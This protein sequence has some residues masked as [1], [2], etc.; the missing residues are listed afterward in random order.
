MR[1]KILRCRF[2]TA[3]A[4]LDEWE[5]VENSACKNAST[6]CSANVSCSSGDTITLGVP[7]GTDYLSQLLAPVLILDQKTLPTPVTMTTANN[8]AM[9]PVMA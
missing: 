4:E 1:L 9:Q 7:D 8:P 5:R 6:T 2:S 3:R